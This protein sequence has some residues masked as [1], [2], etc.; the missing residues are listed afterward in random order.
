MVL[1][2][3]DLQD[4]VVPTP[5]PWAGNNRLQSKQTQPMHLT[6][7]GPRE[8]PIPTL[9]IIL[10]PWTSQGGKEKSEEQTPTPWTRAAAASL[11]IPS[12]GRACHRLNPCPPL[13]HLENAL[14]CQKGNA[15]S[16]PVAHW[17]GNLSVK[18]NYTLLIACVW[19]T[20]FRNSSWFWVV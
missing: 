11:S 4:H 6:H 12:T 20:L 7:S 1:L 3:R 19:N 8:Y 17:E 5:Q 10:A 2:G 18:Q 14:S 16:K 13:H 15:V 9:A